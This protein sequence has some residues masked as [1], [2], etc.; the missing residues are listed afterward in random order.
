[1]LECHISADKQR[2]NAYQE[3]VHQVFFNL[4]VKHE[5]YELRTCIAFLI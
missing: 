2:K 5:A 1:M 4:E 3:K